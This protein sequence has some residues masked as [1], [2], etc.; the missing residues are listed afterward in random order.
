MAFM[1]YKKLFRGTLAVLAAVVVRI[2]L[3]ELLSHAFLPVQRWYF[4]KYVESTDPDP[5]FLPLPWVPDL[6][7]PLLCSMLSGVLAA[8]IYQTRSLALSIIVGLT[9]FSGYLAWW[10]KAVLWYWGIDVAGL[11]YGAVAFLACYL[12]QILLEKRTPRDAEIN[13]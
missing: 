12:T 2:V 8:L 9:I 5:P 13:P 11:S 6:V 4:H 7:F 1:R 10:Y 3:T